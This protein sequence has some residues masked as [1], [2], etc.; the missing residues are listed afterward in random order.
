MSR[1]AVLSTLVLWAGTTMAL[2]HL[3][4]FRRLPLAERLRPFE[5]GGARSS[6]PLATSRSLDEVITPLANTLG[7]RLSRGFG[8][9]EELAL[10]LERV[11]SHHDTT[12]F[13]TRQLTMSLVGLAAAVLVLLA[14]RPP[15]PVALAGLLC[16]P[17]L[18][19]LL[20]EQ[21][22]A[23]QSEQH[24]RR[25]F[26]ELPVVAEQIGMLLSSGYSI[27]GALSRIATR[28]NG[29]C[30]T[31]LRRVTNRIRQGLDTN[32]ALLEWARVANVPT[33]HQLVSVLTLHQDTSDLG[34]LISSESRSMRRALQRE[35]IERIERRNQQVW[36]PV[37]VA[38]LVPGVIFLAV[39]FMSA[40]SGFSGI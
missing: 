36:I 40:L 37:T 5:T 28:G 2:S 23:R 14:V 27:N 13:R 4:W 19:F 25:L 18:A 7:E 8:V 35:L 20:V 21:G 22:L 10:R 39:P 1:L 33:L 3:R 31:D 9:S 17:L 6:R 16:G 38:T 34:A 12:S 11:H 26:L 24:Q 32:L 30:A 15:G 29:V